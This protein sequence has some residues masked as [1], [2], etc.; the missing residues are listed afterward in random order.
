MKKMFNTIC[1]LTVL[2][3]SPST[4]AETLYDDL[5]G[6]AGVAKVVDEF[7]RLVA[8]DTRIN[9]FFKDTNID[10]L[11]MQLNDQVCAATGGGCSYKG[12][13]MVTA[14]AGM[15]VKTVHFNALAEDLQTAMSR[16]GVSSATQNKLIA[17]LAPMHREIVAE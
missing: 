16:H 15:G 2:V 10:H 11:K 8:T 9:L 4:M 1:A 5:G 6:R 3:S 12:R 17:K 13:D 14:H 7:V